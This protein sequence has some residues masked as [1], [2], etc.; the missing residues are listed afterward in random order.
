MLALPSIDSS[1]VLRVLHEQRKG[2]YYTEVAAKRES[3]KYPTRTVRYRAVAQRMTR[4]MQQH[5]ND[6]LLMVLHVYWKCW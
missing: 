1:T 3:L 6:L 4:V 2:L 5:F